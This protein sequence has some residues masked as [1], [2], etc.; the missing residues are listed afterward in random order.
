MRQIAIISFLL[1]LVVAPN[2][3]A[4]CGGV[5]SNQ[6]IVNDSMPNWQIQ[7]QILGQAQPGETI[8]F[9]GGTY[10]PLTFDHPYYS[11]PQ[12]EAGNWITIRS[13]PNETAVI[14]AGLDSS[15]QYPVSG[16][17]FSAV[18][19]MNSARYI[20]I[21]GFDIRSTYGGGFTTHAAFGVTINSGA[22]HIRIVEN[23]ISNFPGNGV[24][25]STVDFLDIRANRIFG[26]ANWFEMQGSGV[27]L[28]KL[29]T[30]PNAY[31]G[32]FFVNRYGVSFHNVVSGN[33]I[34]NNENK[35]NGPAHWADYDPNL[36]NPGVTD[37]N[38]VIMD[39]NVETQN[40]DG[41]SDYYWGTTLIENN[42]C[43]EN[44]GRGIHVLN[45]DNVWVMNNTLYQNGRTPV[46]QPGTTNPDVCTLAPMAELSIATIPR[47]DNGTVPWVT[48]N[49]V[50]NNLVIGGSSNIPLLPLPE[51]EA[52]HNIYPSNGLPGA[53]FATNMYG[54]EG[55]GVRNYGA[56]V[57][58]GEYW[59][60][61]LTWQFQFTNVGARDFEIGA[62][63][64]ASGK[65]ALWMMPE[66]DFNGITREE[67]PSVGAYE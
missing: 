37:G 22:H 1:G 31:N 19:P 25:A 29:F 26:N 8:C 67:P 53:I 47:E 62:G 44:G 9:R 49:R 65:G 50:M 66:V 38:C 56:A 61:W 35:V 57:D 14:E 39:R 11:V 10:G 58:W 21:R 43:Y 63:S 16:V 24:G 55:S 48:E 5:C 46:C 64:V 36:Q 34:Y 52:T 42:V 13:C 40:L 23:T 12:G 30:A 15:G 28:Y 45:S 2:G 17:S 20:E 18:N 27:S 60:P 41:Q 59:T 7:E 51:V 54:E 3:F 6:T 32:D 33:R 4:F